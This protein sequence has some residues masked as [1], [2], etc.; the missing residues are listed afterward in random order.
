LS[1]SVETLDVTSLQDTDRN[2]RPGLRTYTGT[3]NFFYTPD[4]DGRQTFGSLIRRSMRVR[5][6]DDDGDDTTF[7][8]TAIAD[9]Q[10]TTY[11][12]KLFIADNN[13]GADNEQGSPKS[14]YIQLRC[15]ITS[16]DISVNTGDVTGGSIGFQ[17]IGALLKVAVKK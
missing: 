16:M 9:E 7:M 15:I 1:Q 6:P 13:R 14:F 10:P 11:G 17:V 4:E 8:N 3:A 12:L 5:L 2:Y